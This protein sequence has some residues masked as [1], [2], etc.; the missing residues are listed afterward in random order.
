MFALARYAGLRRS[1]IERLAW[2]DI[3]FRAGSITVHGESLVRTTKSRLRKCPLTRQLAAILADVHVALPGSAGP[4][5]GMGANNRTRDAHAIVKR[6]GL[7]RYSKPLHTLRKSLETDWIDRYP[8]ADV[9]E[10]LG[11]S[12]AV[13]LAYYK[14]AT[15]ESFAR[16]A[17]ADP[18]LTRPAIDATGK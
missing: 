3:D 1:E 18:I 6:A 8:I 4:C 12:P 5:D 10:W 17:G 16:A 11:N 2:A 14:R 9:C 15:P 13:A 7:E